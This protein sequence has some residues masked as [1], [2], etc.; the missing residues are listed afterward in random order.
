MI[1]E[2]IITDDGKGINQERIPHL[3]R[4]FGELMQSNR[5]S[6]ESGIGVGL[7]CSKIIANAING[8]VNFL[9]N[10]LGKTTLSV[11]LRVKLYE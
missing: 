3:F 7:Y 5:S 10:D 4:M 2:T 11:T 9:P 1:Y 6:E 8:D